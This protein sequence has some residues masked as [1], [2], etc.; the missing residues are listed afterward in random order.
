VAGELE[1][2]RQ[3][4]RC[5]G[6]AAHQ[7][8]V[9]LLVAHHPRVRQVRRLVE[10]AARLQRAVQNLAPLVVEPVQLRLYTP[11]TLRH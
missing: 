2:A 8:A 7:A 10:L 3:S 1:R 9:R 4:H 11:R 6:V 5:V